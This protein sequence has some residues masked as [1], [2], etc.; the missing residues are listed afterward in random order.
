MPATQTTS[1]LARA[2]NALRWFPIPVDYALFAVANP[3][4]QYRI[5]TLPAYAY[6]H[7]ALWVPIT[8]FAGNIA[9]PTMTVYCAESR[10]LISSF[11]LNTGGK[12]P[13]TLADAARF[14]TVERGIYFD[15]AVG[16]G[17]L[18]LISAGAGVLQLLVSS[19]PQTVPAAAV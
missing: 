4:G 9:T 8:P 11:D 15:P 12:V 17:T 19:I 18:S 16:S 10:Q 1:E 7:N 5:G 2:G 6:V 14:D 3:F 13:L